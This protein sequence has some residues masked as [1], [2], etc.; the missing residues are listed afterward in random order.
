M[1]NQK[2]ITD[3]H[4]EHQDWEKKLAFY[5]DEIKIMKNRLSEVSAKNT[6]SA[7]KIKVEQYQNSFIIQKNE[8]DQLKHAIGKEESELTANLKENPV[9]YTH[10]KLDDNIELRGKIEIFDPIFESLKADFNQF[11]A[12]N[13]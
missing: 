2:Y 9:A 1:E 13:L 7:I 4:Q 3:L 12:E 5:E 11:I 6:D 10:R 8:I